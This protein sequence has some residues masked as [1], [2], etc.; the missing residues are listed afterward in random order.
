MVSPPWVRTPPPA[1]CDAPFYLRFRKANFPD[2]VEPTHSKSSSINSETASSSN[3]AARVIKQID[4]SANFLCDDYLNAN[5]LL[6]SIVQR[7]YYESF[8][9]TFQYDEIRALYV[10]E[11][12]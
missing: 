1:P 2:E 12:D 4:G 10:K 7:E 5:T 6:I 3:S 8:S 9:K 11:S